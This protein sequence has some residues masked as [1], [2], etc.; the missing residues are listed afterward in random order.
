MAVP[1]HT[2][3][4]TEPLRSLAKLRPRLRRDPLVERSSRVGSP[5]LESGTPA[6]LAVAAATSRA[7]VEVVAI[8]NH[9]A[10]NHAN[11]DRHGVGTTR[12]SVV[13]EEPTRRGVSSNPRLS[14]RV[15]IHREYF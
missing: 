7:T 3:D 8:E 2:S 13:T 9:K 11:V 12:G 14:L 15:D 4:R 1:I 10:L 5:A 6:G